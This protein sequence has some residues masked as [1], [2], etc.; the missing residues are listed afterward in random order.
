MSKQTRKSCSRC[1]QFEEQLMALRGEIRDLRE[2]LAAAHTDSSTSSKPPS[3][4]IVKP[5]RVEPGS[6]VGPRAPC[7][8]HG[9]PKHERTP[10]APEQIQEFFDH[11]IE[12]CPDCGGRLRPSGFAAHVVQQVE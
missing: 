6:D 12:V 1:R 2:K 3:S 5:P 7:G 9:H 8:Q 10:F 11:R 4:D